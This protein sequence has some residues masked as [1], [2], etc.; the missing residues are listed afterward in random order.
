MSC[1]MDGIAAQSMD[2]HKTLPVLSQKG[3]FVIG[4]D[5]DVGKTFVTSL[6][7]VLAK[8]DGYSVGMVKPVASGA[9]PMAQ[10]SRFDED[11]IIPR[12][13]AIM[14]DTETFGII[15]ASQLESTDATMLMQAIGA[16]EDR[17]SEV[18]PYALPGEYSPKLAARLAGVK[19][20]YDELVEHIHHVVNKYD[21]TFVEGAGGV[22][23]PLTEDRTFTDLAKDSQLPALLVADGRLGSINRVILTKEYAEHHG[24][25]VKGIIVNNTA[26]VEPFL[27][28]T[29]IEDM[30][31]YTHIPV[32]GVIPPF[33]GI[34]A[35]N[36]KVEWAREFIDSKHVWQVL[37]N[38]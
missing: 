4:T 14:D 10:S 15:H 2:S 29:N 9:I 12:D 30:E 5:T 28:H 18:N 7:G 27:L 19:I 16:G 33:D 1:K 37:G 32:L 25:Y 24:I 31:R 22:T 21:I 17:R 8:D 13:E 36:T 26:Q 34:D 3:V 23:T 11:N 35:W 20:P 6:L 38:E